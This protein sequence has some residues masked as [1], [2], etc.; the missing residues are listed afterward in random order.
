MKN[1]DLPSQA[2]D[3]DCSE[4]KPRVLREKS[5]E[6]LFYS[7]AWPELLPTKKEQSFWRPSLELRPLEVFLI[8]FNIYTFMIVLM[9][10]QPG[11]QLLLLFFYSLHQSKKSPWG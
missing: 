6:G 8:A 1:R 7:F 5:W 10:S 11:M 9:K 3:A 2:D 4:S